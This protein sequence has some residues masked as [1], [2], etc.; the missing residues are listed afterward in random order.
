LVVF[1]GCDPDTNAT[2]IAMFSAVLQRWWLFSAEVP[3]YDIEDR[4]RF[5]TTSLTIPADN[6]PLVLLLTKGDPVVTAV[7]WPMIYPRLKARPNDILSL[8][9]VAG[10]AMAKLPCSVRSFLPRPQTWKG[11]VPKEIAQK[12]YLAESGLS[13]KSPEFASI[14]PK[15]RTHVVDAIGLALWARKTY[16]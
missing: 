2:G 10:M 9:T 12:R 5:M 3:P 1:I 14:K 4:L 7:E 8:A 16:A 11:T 6:L 13:L 15:F